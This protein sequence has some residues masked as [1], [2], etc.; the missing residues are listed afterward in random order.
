MRGEV[1]P[2]SG[3]KIQTKLLVVGVSFLV[4]PILGYWYAVEFSLF[5]KKGQEEALLLSAQ[6]VST[7]LYDRHDVFYYNK[8]ASDADEIANGFIVRPIHGPVITDGEIGDWTDGMNGQLTFGTKDDGGDPFFKMAAGFYKDRLFL[9]L[10]VSDDQLL[11]RNH[12]H[13]RLDNSDHIRITLFDGDDEPVNYL[14]TAYEAGPVSVYMTGEDWKYPQNLLPEGSIRGAIK[15]TEKG[16]TIELDLPREMLGKSSKIRVGV[17]DVDNQVSR[18]VES[19]TEGLSDPEKG[20]LEMIFEKPPEFER[21]F[22]G[23][24]LSNASLWIIDPHGRVRARLGEVLANDYDPASARRNDLVINSA[25][26]GE[27]AVRTRSSLD[28][29]GEIIMASAPILAEG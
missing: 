1:K 13:N 21:I 2:A 22:S 20:Y 12:N 29:T 6:A 23:L 18:R 15:G 5:L 7:A 25:L 28:N 8:A 27:A 4:I 10:S 9:L 26:G 17:A 16:Y 14:V 3:L 19:V 24:N 11:Y